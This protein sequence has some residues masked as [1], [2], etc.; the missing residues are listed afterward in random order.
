MSIIWGHILLSY[1]IHRSLFGFPVFV[2]VIQCLNPAKSW[3][4]KP[5]RRGSFTP[6]FPSCCA[7]IACTF[8]E[9]YKAKAC[10]QPLEGYSAT[11]SCSSTNQC[12][13]VHHSCKGPRSQQTSRLE[14][15]SYTRNTWPIPPSK[16]DDWEILGLR[17][18]TIWRCPRVQARP[19]CPLKHWNG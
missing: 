19:F 1:K 12:L 16:G 3:Q 6:G 10:D 5:S 17:F 11:W 7:T 4:D 8:V 18:P 13:I 15:H 9:V 2:R 14:S